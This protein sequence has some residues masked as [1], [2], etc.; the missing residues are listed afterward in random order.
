MTRTAL[1]IAY[2]YPPAGGPGV[3]RSLK[4]SKYLPAFG[5]RS[6]VVTATEP[7]HPVLDPTLAKDIPADTTLVRVPA[8]DIQ[9]LRP[10]FERLHLGKVLSALN[11]AFYLPDTNLPWAYRARSAARKAIEAERPDVVYTTS[12]PASAHLL[13]LWVHQTFGLPWVADF[14]DPWSQNELF[15]YYP[16]YRALNRRMEARVL[17]TAGRITTVSAPLVEMFRGLSG[18]TDDVVLIENGYDEDDVP[19]LPAPKTERFTITYTGE[20]NR[21]RRPDAF[22]EAIDRL[23]AQGRIPLQ[24]IRVAFAGKDTRSFIPDRPPFEQL[25]YLSHDALIAL[26][27]NSDLLLLI[28]NDSE[29]GRGNFGGKFYEYIGCNRPT[30]AV[31][32]ADNVAAERLVEARAG[33]V[34]GHD[35]AEIGEAIVSYYNRWRSGVFDYAPDWNVIRAYTRRNLAGRLADVFDELVAEKK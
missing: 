27:R 5:W 22:V 31:T 11:V 29:K 20:F 15:R 8:H 9:M 30:L 13:G 1:F 26:R 35:P 34:V 4:F 19:V 24:E 17:S 21:L 25:G 23:I 3:Q 33:T 16:G 12:S 14:R 7:D 2:I 6:A 10:R 28:H 32:G 18:R